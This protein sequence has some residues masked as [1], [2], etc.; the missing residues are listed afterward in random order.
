MMQTY[1]T[2]AIAFIMLL[3]LPLF[4]SR[5]A[6]A[7][8]VSAGATVWY[9]WWRAAHS[10]V[11]TDFGISN[12]RLQTMSAFMYGPVV[13]VKFH[14]DWTLSSRFMIG[15]FGVKELEG[16][17]Y[18]TNYDTF[19]TRYR[20]LK[21]DSDTTLGYSVSRYV[22]LFAG[23]KIMGYQRFLNRRSNINIYP[24]SVLEN[25]V[26]ITENVFS[27]TYGPGGGLG[28]VA[29]L[30]DGLYASL[31]VNGL[32]TVGESRT[33]LYSYVPN[34]PVV[35]GG[36]DI[37]RYISGEFSTVA[38]VVMWGGNIDAA[39]SY[40]ILSAQTTVAIGGRFQ[41]LKV[42]ARDRRD[43]VTPSDGS[44]RDYQDIFGGITVSAL[45]YFGG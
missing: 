20:V 4:S 28:L 9:A 22:R 41:I 17:A 5:T 15:N 27:T 8:D 40:Y 39:V 30:A 18:G 29:P 38:D 13:S 37:T 2:T 25:Y 31:N 42:L 32:Y 33:R 6:A 24:F 3:S 1:G 7:A 36:S 23:V 16:R 11:D 10:Q 43:A 26:Y 21:Y 12:D 35:L 14:D 19:T 45:Y 44:D 34:R